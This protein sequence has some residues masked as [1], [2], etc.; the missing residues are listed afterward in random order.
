MLTKLLVI[1]DVEENIE[2]VQWMLLS[3][4]IVLSKANDGVSGVALADEELFDVI[5]MDIRMPVVDGLEATRRIRRGDGL[6]RKAPILAFTADYFPDLIA[7]YLR[8][9]LTGHLAKPFSRGQLLAA[10]SQAT[11]HRGGVAGKTA[12]ER[13]FAELR[14]E[15]GDVLLTKMLEHFRIMLE[16][17]IQEPASSRDSLRSRS[18]QIRGSA[19][20]VGFGFLAEPCLAL[21]TACQS[22]GDIEL[23]L[24]AVRIVGGLALSHLRE[25]REALASGGELRRTGSLA[26][27]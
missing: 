21:E 18:H 23:T 25:M 9:G 1:D 11:D 22:G 20:M 7:T 14:A 2:I 26:G 16:P 5:L 27:S 17:L 8:A 13:S 19:G 15:Y 10:L 6:S 12:V 24:N 3:N 4:P